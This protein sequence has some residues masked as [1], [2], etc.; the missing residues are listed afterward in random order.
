MRARRGRIELS[1][2]R[3]SW[4]LVLV[5]AMVVVG[6]TGSSDGGT[7][8]ADVRLDCR[9]HGIPCAW[10]GV[11]DAAFTATMAL[12]DQAGTALDAGDDPAAVAAGL[13][14]APDVVAV[15]H[16]ATGVQFR[17]E[18]A[19]VVVAHAPLASPLYNALEA[20]ARD[21]GLTQ[22]A[23]PAAPEAGL[24]ASE[25]VV[26]ATY[27]TTRAPDIRPRSALLIR[28][29]ESFDLETL[30]RIMEAKGLVDRGT[31]PD[32]DALLE[33]VDGTAQVFRESEHFTV[34]RDDSV[35]AFASFGSHDV[36][37]I[38]T[39]SSTFGA[40]R[41]CDPAAGHV[42]GPVLGGPVLA[43]ASEDDDPYVALQF[44]QLERLPVGATV[45]RIFDQWTV[46][47]TAD[48][49]R[50]QYRDQR[51]LDTILF[52]NA[53]KTGGEDIPVTGLTSA[54]AGTDTGG[55][56]GAVFAW[57]NA[58]DAIEADTTTSVVAQLLVDDA[59]PA[60]TAMDIVDRDPGLREHLVGGV[61]SARLFRLGDDVR[62]RDA[63]RVEGRG[64][65]MEPGAVIQ[66]VGEPED[67][68]D[69]VIAAL[70]L[71]V[72]GV[73]VD[74][75]DTAVLRWQLPVRHGEPIEVVAP[76]SGA[77]AAVQDVS[78]PEDDT[79]RWQDLL[80]TFTN[81]D[82][83]FDLE[84]D[85]LV[86]C[87]EHTLV[88]ELEDGDGEVTRHEIAPVFLRQ[89]V[90]EVLDPEFGQPL[91]AG[92][93]VLLDGAARDGVDEVYP[94][95]VSIDHVDREQLDA[96]SLTVIVA[97]QVLDFPSSTWEEVEEGRYRVERSVPLHDFDAAEEVI[98]V[99][100]RLDLPER[101]NVVHQVD[102]LVL[103]LDEREVSAC[104]LFTDGEVTSALGRPFGEPAP[105]LLRNTCR[106]AAARS[107]LL[108]SVWTPAEGEVL[109]SVHD[110][111]VDL[112]V[113]GIGERAYYEVAKAQPPSGTRGDD[114][115][116]SWTNHVNLHVEVNAR[117]F[118]IQVGGNIVVEDGTDVI[119]VGLAQMVELI[120]DRA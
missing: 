96:M 26:A 8:S 106:W 98:L 53:C 20:L 51:P 61:E 38:E 42:C 14:D 79:G 2:V 52:L 21:G 78:D 27:G 67:G 45:G 5:L 4:S 120:A 83:E 112:Q 105:T 90:V 9:D 91:A 48:Y 50:H 70:T 59:L 99:D 57:T 56:G 87:R 75:W 88:V 43:E 116:M 60:A 65:T 35:E 40:S 107:N 11:E 22:A 101:G 10:E 115:V 102:P 110:E 37:I 86:C 33:R 111:L 55:E 84:R 81:L 89:E 100:A 82:L 66:V 72:E 74:E 15:A 30:H 31:E 29:W 117:W 95:V 25:A 32:W 47:F 16:D 49:F 44:A 68:N 93:R 77:G 108:V 28:P 19:P 63:I 54:I 64:V 114:G 113:T 39:H 71:R 23:G 97:D 3:R 36:V 119:L 76:F 80:V 92:D 1:R 18:G 17:V 109:A 73:L 7:E 34:T 6:C 12:L 41:G 62:A 94:L 103:E 85:D 24:G 13:R 58:I 46:A 118:T 104:D 69:D